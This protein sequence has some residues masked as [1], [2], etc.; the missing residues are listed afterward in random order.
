MN[1]T[2][3][4]PGA[5]DAT[6]TALLQLARQVLD[7]HVREED[8]DYDERTNT[9]TSWFYC[10]LCGNHRD[11]GDEL[12]PCLPHQLAAGV[13]ALRPLLEHDEYPHILESTRKAHGPSTSVETLLHL[14]DG[15][16]SLADGGRSTAAYW[17]AFVT[18]L[19][20]VLAE[21]AL[22]ARDAGTGQEAAT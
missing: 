18:A 22:T 14:R 8:G 20:Q 4:T 1:E 15:Y 10:R 11:D 21:R 9:S 16:Q 13:L 6:P 5:G 3:T 2:P 17:Q 19:D 12:W 7:E